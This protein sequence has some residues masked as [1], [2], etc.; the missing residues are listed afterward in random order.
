MGDDKTAECRPPPCGAD[1]RRPRASP[2]RPRLTRAPFLPRFYS[3]LRGCRCSECMTIERGPYS[4]LMTKDIPKYSHRGRTPSQ[5]PLS[6]Q[7]ALLERLMAVRGKG[8][9]TPWQQLAVEERVPRTNLERF[10]RREV[11]L[12]AHAARQSLYEMFLDHLREYAGT[13]P[14]SLAAD[15][16]P[17]PRSKR[18]PEPRQPGRQ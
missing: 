11:R 6:E 16:T 7:T 4:R 13:A 14:A 1:L 10:Y 15:T 8:R 5:M 18:K 17:P 9:P 12:E 2:S 3:R